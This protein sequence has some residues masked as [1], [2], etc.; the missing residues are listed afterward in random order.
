MATYLWVPGD[1]LRLPAHGGYRVWR[2]V[3]VFLG[4]TNQASVIEIESLDQQDCTE[5]RMC[6]PFELLD[7]A[8]GA[9][10]TDAK[11]HQ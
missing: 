9:I 4:G 1:I 10:L 2:V 6:V 8:M 5:G 11:I 7:A 3:G